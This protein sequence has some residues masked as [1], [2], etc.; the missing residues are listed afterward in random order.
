[1]TYGKWEDLMD[2]SSENRDIDGTNTET[3]GMA[4]PTGCIS[5]PVA[6]GAG[7]YTISI[8]WRGHY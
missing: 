3:G 2:G 7:V 8:V 6:G 1:M 4:S 5:G